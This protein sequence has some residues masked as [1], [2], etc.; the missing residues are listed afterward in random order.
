MKKRLLILLVLIVTLATPVAANGTARNG[1]DDL[2]G[3]WDVEFYFGDEYG[4]E[5]LEVR[6]LIQDIEPHPE[7]ENVFL[8][9]GCMQTNSTGGVAPLSLV[10]TYLP[11]ENR[12]EIMLYSTVIPVE[13]EPFVI[14][15]I[16]EV[17]VNGSG[18]KD[19]ESQGQ[20]RSDLGEGPW[21]ADHH[22]RRKPHC[23]DMLDPS[24]QFD[25]DVYAHQDLAPT[26]PYYD[27][28][29]ATIT[30]IVSS[31]MIVETPD[32]ENIFVYPYTDIFSPDVDF[33]S[34]FRYLSSFEGP[35]IIGDAYTFTLLD[36]LGNPIP[37]ATA[38]DVW[39]ECTQGAPQNIFIEQALVGDL[40]I[41]WDAVPDA[42]GWD[43]DGDPQIGFYQIGFGP[44][45][46]SQTS[47]GANSIAST[48]HVVPWNSFT[49][50]ADGDPDGYDYGVS[51]SELDDGDYEVNVEAFAQAPSWSGGFGL[52]CATRDSNELYQ[53]TKMSEELTFT[54]LGTIAGQVTNQSGEPL[55]GVWV[56]ACEYSDE[57]QF[58]RSGHTKENGEYYVAGLL[59]GDYRVQTRGEGYAGEFYNDTYQW[60]DATPVVVNSGVTT[61][62]IDFELALGGSISGTVFDESG[63]PLSNIAVDIEEGGYGTCTDENGNYRMS[64]MLLGTYTLVAGRDFCNPHNYIE[65]RIE[66]VELTEA[67]PDVDGVDFKLILGGSIS[68][69]VTD[70]D[71]AVIAGIHVEACE[72]SDDP[73]FCR[74][75]ETDANGDYL[76][77]GLFPTT[78]LPN[79]YRV[80][81]GDENYVQEFYDGVFE[82]H[83]ATAVPVI[84]G[85]TTL[86]IDFELSLGG[87]IS[88][89]VFDESG[90]NPLP[91]I[92]VDIE[93]GGFG[94]CTDENGNYTMSGMPLGTYTVVAG[95]DFCETH[96]YVEQAI[97]GIVLTTEEPDVGGINFNLVMGGGISGVVTVDDDPAIFLGD[98][99]VVACIYDGG[100]CKDTFSEGN[101]TYIIRGLPSGDYRVYADG[102]GYLLEFYNGTNDWDLAT[103][104]AVTAGAIT[105]GKN[106]TLTHE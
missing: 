21:T 34:E 44:V 68:G 51:L 45:F 41:S 18:V 80:W 55:A 40:V 56:D 2:R 49:P 82:W 102:E 10:A 77:T 85:E 26:T 36:I 60:P 7:E 64:G 90:I 16:G 97:P 91:N 15:F 5:Q 95:R 88:G 86:G 63:L 9:N 14:R 19:D 22:D 24:L 47:Y 65:G 66:N 13:G 53:M 48:E 69:T 101:G 96:N 62:G 46:E 92:A 57:P 32:G 79:G 31:G 11:E 100:Y 50:G 99:Q 17:I 52:E 59:P 20:H 78:L 105:E 39:M 35:P 73:Q 84:A 4:G 58:C 87:S 74:G 37:G 61:G 8:A 1:V 33:V 106:F 25:A 103:R 104:V 12:Y 94:T 30:R 98:I 75:A 71:G 27:K 93:Q 83:E 23:G 54:R 29:Y 89:T 43:P 3:R 42:D 67:T 38:V 81:T 6:W 76:I 72:Y 70:I 28:L